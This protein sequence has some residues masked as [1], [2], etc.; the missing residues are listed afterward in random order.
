MAAA[1]AIDNNL[2][3][4]LVAGLRNMV[5]AQDA[6]SGKIVATLIDAEA[7]NVFDCLL[8]S[9][10]FQAYAVKHLVEHAH[11]KTAEHF[12]DVLDKKGLT[13][14][15]GRIHKEERPARSSKFRIMVVDDSKTML[16]I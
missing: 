3:T 9:E 11:P 7:N 10:A 14:L 2:S 4:I 15:I 6:Q 1:K 8:D 16:K 5:D 13:G 12:I